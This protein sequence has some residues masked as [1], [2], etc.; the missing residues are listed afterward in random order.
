MRCVGCIQG[1]AASCSA[2][3]WLQIAPIA[4]WPA[5]A[6]T[7]RPCVACRQASTTAWWVEASAAAAL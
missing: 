7:C 2:P 5:G 1:A 3:L 6:T 4:S